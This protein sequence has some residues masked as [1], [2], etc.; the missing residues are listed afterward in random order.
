MKQMGTVHGATEGR[1]TPGD[2]GVPTAPRVLVVEDDPSWQQLLTEMLTDCGLGVDHAGDAESAVSTL[3]AVPHRLAVVD[4]S[5]GGGD[6]LNQDGLR[7]LAAVR[8]HDPACTALLLTGFAT[9]ELAVSALTEYG[10][11]TCLRK[12]AFQR[13]EFREVIRRALASAPARPAPQPE[14]SPAGGYPASGEVNGTRPA[15]PRILVVEDDAGWRSILAE[16]LHEA[17][18][19][20]RLCS[21]YGEALGCLRRANYRLA[22]VD[23]SLDPLDRVARPDGK[24][25][26]YRLLTGAR[27]AGIPAIVVSGVATPAEIERFYAER[28]VYACLEKQAFDRRLFRQTVIEALAPG[29]AQSGRLDSLTGRE[30]EV[31]RLLAHGLTNQEIAASLTITTNTVKRHLKSIFAKLDVHTRSAAATKFLNPP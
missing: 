21:S 3:R 13:A 9:V 12:E 6:V 24:P 14:A 4:L 28:L 11:F 18:C 8:R 5:L 7:V 26:G 19:Q 20:V 30:R 25:D 23:L 17:G 2:P 16:I 31:L 29:G 10:A 27:R 15:A 22:V 1:P